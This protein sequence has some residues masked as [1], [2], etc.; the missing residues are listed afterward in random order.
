MF[1]TAAMD[2]GD[3]QK[4]VGPDWESRPPTATPE[5]CDGWFDSFHLS[6]GRLFAAP[7]PYV[8]ARASMCCT[9]SAVSSFFPVDRC[10]MQGSQ[11]PLKPE[12]FRCFGVVSQN[13]GGHT[14]PARCDFDVCSY[15]PRVAKGAAFPSSL[16]STAVCRA[17]RRTDLRFL[18]LPISN[19]C[20]CM[21]SRSDCNSHFSS[22]S[23][24]PCPIG[25][26]AETDD[27]WRSRG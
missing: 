20:C 5:E 15:Q 22:E 27:E 19:H 16:G 2:F 9:R 3:C 21:G 14:I 10:A 12:L 13:C 8:S 26:F 24:R 23:A 7:T 4:R 18:N 1:C 11:R 17:R 25:I 6:L